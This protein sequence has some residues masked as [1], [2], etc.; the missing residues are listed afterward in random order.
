MG[1]HTKGWGGS[2]VSQPCRVRQ[3]RPQVFE[4]WTH[5]EAFKYMVFFILTMVKQYFN[6]NLMPQEKG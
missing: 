2:T 5:N 6:E 4:K 1:L 3:R